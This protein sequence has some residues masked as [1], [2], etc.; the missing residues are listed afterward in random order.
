MSAVT[1]Q[2]V[3]GQFCGADKEKVEGDVVKVQRYEDDCVYIPL[4]VT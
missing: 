4:S 1:K 2:V 3:L